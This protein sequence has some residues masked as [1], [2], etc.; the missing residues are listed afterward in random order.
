M[1]ITVFAALVLLGSA[2]SAALA[3]PVLGAD[4]KAGLWEDVLHTN[5]IQSALDPLN[6]LSPQKRRKL[7]EVLLSGP[8]GVQRICATQDEAQHPQLLAHV[9]KTCSSSN[10]TTTGRSARFD[11]TCEKNAHYQIAIEFVSPEHITMAETEVVASDATPNIGRHD[12]RWL[13]TDCGDIKPGQLR[14]VVPLFEQKAAIAAYR[15][16]IK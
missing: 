15:S 3:D 12:L 11:L 16:V 9:G 13:A 10:A 7:T 6:E 8:A 14:E 2:A 4:N 1:R 5:W